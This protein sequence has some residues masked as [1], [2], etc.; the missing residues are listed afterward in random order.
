MAD[1]T[2]K[3][4]R[5]C[6][7][8]R[9][10]IHAEA[11]KCR[12]CASMLVPL[13]AEPPKK[14]PE[15][16]ADDGKI[17]G[18]PGHIMVMVYKDLIRFGKVAAAFLSLIVVVGAA[19]TGLDLKNAASDAN[20]AANDAK[21]SLNDIQQSR[22][23]VEDLKNQLSDE[24]SKVKTQLAEMQ[25]TIN[26][27]QLT[28]PAAREIEL[29][30]KALSAQGAS[31][32]GKSNPTTGPP[33]AQGPLTVPQVARLYNFPAN[34]NGEGQ[35]IAMI[36]LGGGYRPAD[37]QTY[38]SSLNLPVPAVS[39][40]GVDGA[41]NNPTT[42]LSAD[43]QVD[44][45]LEVAGAVAPKAHFSL[46]FA[47]NTPV[48]F[49][50]AVRTATNDKAYPPSILLIDWGSPEKTWTAG[51]LHQLDNALHDAAL[52]GIT[53]IAA[54][55]DQGA[56]DGTSSPAVDFPSSSP[57]VLSVG[58]TRLSASHDKIVSEVVWN[59]LATITLTPAQRKAVASF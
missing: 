51:S 39:V 33:G 5:E 19:L 11:I 59:N 12:H 48:G 23:Q 52:R 29:T 7:F 20:K 2:G 56:T 50:D 41:S 3:P 34:L 46:C 21:T 14:D 27:I 26:F 9:E 53:V 38:F 31:S 15:A 8:C 57:S 17:L 4:S 16:D 55:G 35:N 24:Q 1:E 18:K 45:D 22:Q 37:M 32:P 42:A 13:P 6:P 54:S 44:L 28:L 58:G 30:S 43:D 10:T 36:E 25:T 47:P 40:L 49:V